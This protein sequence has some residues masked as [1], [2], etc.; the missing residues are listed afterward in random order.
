MVDKKGQ[1]Q[2]GDGSQVIEWM[3]NTQSCGIDNKIET[4]YLDR[5]KR[6]ERI[7]AKEK[8]KNICTEQNIAV[9]RDGKRV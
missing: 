5:L 9:P 7:D 2:H 4:C 1:F 6:E 3:K 8:K